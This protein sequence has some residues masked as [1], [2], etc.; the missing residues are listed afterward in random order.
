MAEF[1]KNPSLLVSNPS[2]EIYI[3]STPMILA[4]VAAKLTP[5]QIQTQETVKDMLFTM[6]LVSFIC[7]FWT[8]ILSLLVIYN[9]AIKIHTAK[10]KRELKRRRLYLSSI[11]FVSYILV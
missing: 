7:N 2:L 8:I 5:E 9:L 10:K 11:I 4:E 3:P 6:R 1:L